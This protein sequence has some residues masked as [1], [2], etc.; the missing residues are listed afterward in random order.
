MLSALTVHTSICNIPR[1]S[2]K[3]HTHNSVVVHKIQFLLFNLYDFRE[4]ADEPEKKAAMAKLNNYG[5]L[6]L[7]CVK[8]VSLKN[9]QKEKRWRERGVGRGREGRKN[10]RSGKKPTG[11]ATSLKMTP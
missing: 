7:S 5:M 2:L 3:H 1:G 10:D 9:G 11:I 6:F 8:F 4:A